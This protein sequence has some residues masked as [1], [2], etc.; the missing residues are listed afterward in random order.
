M[1][2]PNL[3]VYHTSGGQFPTGQAFPLSLGVV[4]GNPDRG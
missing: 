3:S 4:R 2:P 1:N